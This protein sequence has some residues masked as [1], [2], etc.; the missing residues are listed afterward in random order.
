MKKT[1]LIIYCA[2]F[3]IPCAFF[4]LGM[5]IPGAAEAAEGAEMPKLLTSEP[6]VSV[7]S[8][9]GL[10]FEE[11]FAKS[12][13]YRNKVVDTFSMLKSEIFSDETDQVITGKDDFLFFKETIDDYMGKTTMT[14]EDINAAADFLFEMYTSAKENGSKFLF[15]CAPNKNS[16]YPE[17]MPSRYIADMENRNIDRLYSELD[18]RGVPYIDLRPILTEAKAEQLIYHKRDTHW[19]SEGAR[20]AIE[21]ISEK[22]SLEIDDFSAYEKTQVSDFSGDLDTLLYPGK[23]MYDSDTAYDFTGKF[24]YTYAYSNPMDM[25]ITTRGDGKGK[26]LMFRDS[27]A[28]AMIPFFASS[29]KE[30]LFDRSSPYNIDRHESYKADYVIVEIAERY[31]YK[32]VP[33]DESDANTEVKE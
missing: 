21:A 26:L 30:T 22:L 4:S 31:L 11:Y 28:N 17:M 25:K 23:K 5:I 19:N 13:A 33:T 24:A 12:F 32:L 3:L 20:I 14:D 8:D 9:F 10:E 1:L 18:E 29:C 2:L 16:I 7:N 6:N 15:V 27:F